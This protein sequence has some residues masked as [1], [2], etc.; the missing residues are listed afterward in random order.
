MKTRVRH[1]VKLLPI[2]IFVVS[3]VVM[4]GSYF[5][6]LGD[7]GFEVLYGISL[8]SFISYF[9]IYYL[10]INN[11]KM[12]FERIGYENAVV[13]YQHILKTYYAILISLIFF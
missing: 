13:E 3:V 2:L 10:R 7:F 5:I 1:K 8:A 9:I 12:Y 4:L 11:P 6:S